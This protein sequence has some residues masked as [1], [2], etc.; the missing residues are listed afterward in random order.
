MKIPKKKYIA[1]TL[2][3][4]LALTAASVGITHAATL[5]TAQSK[6][7]MSSLVSAIATKFNLNTTD[8]QQVFDA[9]KAQMDA[10]RQAKDAERLTQAVTDGKLTQAQADLIT[11][12]QKELQTNREALK[13]K[14]EAERQTAMKTEM[15]SLKQWM[16][17]NKIPV[18]YLPVGGPGGHGGR[19]H[20]GPG[21]DGRGPTPTD[22]VAPATGTAPVAN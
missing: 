8:V 11:A 2:A 17:D 4:A 6:N 5:T 7:P 13:D 3:L 16:T 10:E 22:G 18:G 21:M 19:G 1:A 20:G 9:Q 15:D 12:K 14:T